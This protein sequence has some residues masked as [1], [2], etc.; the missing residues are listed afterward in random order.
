MAGSKNASD[1]TSNGSIYSARYVA[2]ISSERW[3]RLIISA[4]L[5]PVME[6]PEAAPRGKLPIL[7][8]SLGICMRL[9]SCPDI[10]FPV[11]RI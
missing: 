3:Y 4:A 9:T 8:P 5:N 6:T 7:S 10:V 2:C 11:I 1:K